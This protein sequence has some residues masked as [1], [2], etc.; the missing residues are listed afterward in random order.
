MAAVF[1]KLLELKDFND[2][3]RFWKKMSSWFVSLTHAVCET[4]RLI[5]VRH[6]TSKPDTVF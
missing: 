5:Y 3:G 2:V 1:V 6:K 4:S